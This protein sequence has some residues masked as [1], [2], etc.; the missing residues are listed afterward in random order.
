MA[1]YDQE[2]GR[3]YRQSEGF[4]SIVEQE[5]TLLGGDA[6]EYA[7]RLREKPLTA[8]SQSYE[9]VEVKQETE[10][11][12]TIVAKLRNTTPIDSGTVVDQSDRKRRRDGET[13]RYVVERDSTGWRLVQAY[14]RLYEGDTEWRPQW[15]PDETYVPTHVSP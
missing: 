4:K 13:V 14:K 11:R 12:A 6:L 2:L 10:S 9:I 15:R 5:R 8:H 7:R 3:A 1:R